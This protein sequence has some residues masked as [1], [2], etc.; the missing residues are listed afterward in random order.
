VW[1][2]G[3]LAHAAWF[4]PDSD[5]DMA[6]EGLPPEDF[7]KAWAAVEDIIRERPVD[8]IDWDMA[9]D[10]LRQA[11]EEFGIELCS[12][13]SQSSNDGGT[14]DRGAADVLGVR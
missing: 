8:L 2:F 3:S 5:V 4:D 7:W 12:G 11:I 14:D 6:V 9:S 13:G 10:S 1:L